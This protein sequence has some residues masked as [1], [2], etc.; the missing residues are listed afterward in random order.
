MPDTEYEGQRFGTEDVCP[1]NE[2]GHKPDWTRVTTSSDGG[3]VYLDVPCKHC[4]RSGCLGSV[5]EVEAEVDW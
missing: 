2:Q 1:N 4:G 3:Q 5:G